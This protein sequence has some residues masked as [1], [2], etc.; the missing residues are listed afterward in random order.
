METG[1]QIGKITRSGTLTEY[2]ISSLSARPSSIASGPD[3]NL[4]VTDSGRNRIIKVSTSG[5]MTSYGIPTAD[6]HPGTITPGPDGSLWF[7]ESSARKVARVTTAGIITEFKLGE[8]D[9]FYPV[10]IAAGPDGNLWVI[11]TG[12]IG[13]PGKLAKVTT[14]GSFTEYPI[15]PAKVVVGRELWRQPEPGGLFV[16][17]DRNLWFAAGDNLDSVTISGVFSQYVVPIAS[18]WGGF[19]GITAGPDGKIWFT[20]HGQD[21]N[22]H[23]Y[24]GR[25]VI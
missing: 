18:A 4:W 10:G 16:G 25:L 24:L 23:N 20:V 2:A 7:V 6:S 8:D 21:S 13:G 22:L 11:E 1:G 5:V 3:G 19:R 12:R 15:P 14:S 17:P 9:W